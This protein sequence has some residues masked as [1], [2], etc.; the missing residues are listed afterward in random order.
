MSAFWVTI[1]I[2]AVPVSHEATGRAVQQTRAQPEEM[3]SLQ[4][5]ATAATVFLTPPGNCANTAGAVPPGLRIVKVTTLFRA[6][7]D[8]PGGHQGRQ[9]R[10]AC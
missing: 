6:V 7:G 4:E 8:L 2:C 1:G 10:P 3:A 9:A 5:T